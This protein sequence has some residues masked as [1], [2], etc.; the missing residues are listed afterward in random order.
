[1]IDN[2][3]T[4][5]ELLKYMDSITYG[6]VD[7]DGNKNIDNM[8]GWYEK[9]CVQDGEGVLKSKVGTCWDQTELERLWFTINN[10]N[11]KTYYMV[12]MV[13]RPNKLPAHSF[14]VYEKDNKWCYF[15]HSWADMRG[16]YEFDTLEDAL[17]FAV[18]K[19]IEFAKSYEDFMPG[20]EDKLRLYEFTKP[21]PNLSAQEQMDFMKGLN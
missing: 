1:M 17:N 3:K 10:Y 14:L 19:H 5:E 6:W 7:K 12:F 8:D 2:I 16:I 11:V 13:G 9:C 18:D 15:E 21:E 20:D 4:P